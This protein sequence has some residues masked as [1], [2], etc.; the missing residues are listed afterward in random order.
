M[1]AKNALRRSRLHHALDQFN[2]RQ[3]LRSSIDQIPDKDCGAAL[4]RPHAT[5]LAIPQFGEK[6]GDLVE[7][8]MDIPA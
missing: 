7:L 3:L 8:A 1:I 5:R 6:A 4:M 2:R